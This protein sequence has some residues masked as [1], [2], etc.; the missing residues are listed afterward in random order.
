M[1]RNRTFEG[2]R[3]PHAIASLRT[4][5]SMRVAAVIAISRLKVD[6][7]NVDTAALRT[8]TAAVNAVL[9]GEEQCASLSARALTVSVR[10]EAASRGTWPAGAASLASP[11]RARRGIADSIELRKSAL[12]IACESNDPFQSASLVSTRPLPRVPSTIRKEIGMDPGSAEES[13]WP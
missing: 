3:P 9:I 8:K 2:P 7:L 11:R 13:P 6:A 1:F 12:Y 10:L 5:V 4:G